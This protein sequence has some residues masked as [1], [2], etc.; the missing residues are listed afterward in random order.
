MLGLAV[1]GCIG[2]FHAAH[3]QTTF[4]ETA[5]G[6]SSNPQTITVT[7]Q[8]TGAVSAVSVLTL[9]QS[10]LDFNPTV[11]G[12]NS[13]TNASF[14]TAGTSSC[15]IEITFTP[16]YPGVRNG[17]IV[18]TGS[19]GNVLAT[20]YLTGTGQGSLGVMVPG[21]MQTAVGTGQWT[22]VNDGG[23]PLA[24]DLDLPSSVA[25][26]GAGNLYIADSAHNRIREVSA[27]DNVISTICGT[28]APGSTGD[29]QSAVNATLNTPRSVAIDGAGNLYIAD[30]GNNAIRE[31][32]KAT[33]DIATIAGNGVPANLDGNAA[34][35]ELNNP[36][37]VTVDAAGDVYIADTSD[38][39]ILTVAPSSNNAV[40]IA[41]DG[42]AGFAGDGGAAKLAELNLP[43]AVAF[44]SLE[45]IYIPDSGN[46]CV[47]VDYV[48]GAEAGKI[49]TFAGSCHTGT[50]S[51]SGDGG[52]PAN[53]NLFAPSAVAIDA[54][55][56]LYI[57][58]TQNN[59]IRKVT[60]VN[61]QLVIN[62][63][64]GTGIGI[65]G[66]DGGS[67][68]AAE[69]FGPYGVTLDG[70]G[71]LFIA[72]YFDHRIREVQSGT[73]TLTFDSLREDQVSPAQI[74][75]I[76]NDGNA[77]MT[78]T[79]ITPDSN[80][81]IGTTTNACSTTASVIIDGTCNVAAEFA[82]TEV[83]SPITGNI[84]LGVTGNPANGPLDIQVSGDALALNSTTT[85]LMAEPNPANFGAQVTLSA[86]VT[87]GTGTLGGSV[88][89]KDGTAI[90]GTVNLTV[91]SSPGTTG[92]ASFTTSALTVGTH[93]LTAVYNGD[94]GVHSASTSPAVSEDIQEQ[95]SVA[96]TSGENPSVSGDSVT[97]TATVSAT[98]D[99]GAAP[100][101]TVNFLSG[102]A[103][104]GTGTLSGNAASFT[105][106]GLTTGTH[107][108]TAAYVGDSDNAGSTSPQL[109]QVVK[110]ITSTS[111]QSSENPASFGDSVRFTATVS[112]GSAT[113][114]GIVTFTD[115]ANGNALLGSSSLINVGSSFTAS[116]SSS[117]L[118]VASH[119]IV[120][121]YSG[122]ANDV[123]S[124]S[125]G[126]AE[127]VQ[128]AST[129]TSLSSSLTPSAS[130]QSVSF[131]VTVHGG[132]TA[133]TGT[134]SLLDGTATVSTMN[135]GANGTV[136]IPVSALSVGTHSLTAV[137]SGD[138]NYL[139]ST[140]LVI[141]QKVLPNTTAILSSSANPSIAGTNVSITVTVSGASGTPTGNVN[142]SDGATPL[143]TLTLVGG[144]ANYQTTS[145][146]VGPHSLT[147]AYAG[148][149]NN[150]GTTSAAYVQ[151]V[152]QATT[153]TTVGASANPATAGRTISLIATV[154]GNG[155]TPGGQVRFFS[156]GTQVG[157]ATLSGGTASLPISSLAVGS[158]SIYATYVGDPN[159]A[160]S[161]SSTY[162]LSV[163]QA[164]SSVNLTSSQNPSVAVRAVGFTAT[165]TGSGVT[166]TGNV[167][168]SDGGISL[169][170]VA[171]TPA[172][173]ANYVTSGLA[174]GVH[175]ITAAYQG[176]G[177]NTASSTSLVQTVTQAAPTLG[178]TS[179]L[180]PSSAGA[181]VTFTATPT[182]AAGTPSGSV[183]FSD[184]S[185][186]IGTA[187]L[188]PQGAATF[189]TSSLSVGQH[190]IT[191]SYG[192]DANNTGAI[193][194]PLT[195][196]VQEMTTTSL[197]SS[198]NPSIGGT[199]VTLTATVL[200]ASSGAISGSV[201][202]KSGNS[203][204][205]AATLSAAGVA[206][207]TT[208]A[209][210]VGSDALTAVYSGDTLHI[211]STSAELTQ[212]VQSA[213]T[214]TTLASNQ[215][216]SLFGQNVTFTATVS[217]NGI[218][219]TGAITF[220]DGST[221]LATVNVNTAG[222]ASYS[223]TTLSIGVH[224]IVASYSGDSDDQKSTS[225]VV[226]QSVQSQTSVALASS[227]N[228]AL[229]A[230][231]VTFTAT[232]TNGNGT[233]PTG[234][235]TIN[236]GSSV[237]AELTL[238]A[239]GTV[240]FTTSTLPVGT[241]SITAA[242][243]GD[244]DDAA[245]KSGTLAQVIQAIPTKTTLGA[246]AA[247]VTTQQPLTLVASVF[248]A[249][250][251][252]L[253][254]TV[255][256]EN[257]TT[258]IG[259]AT[260]TSA[261]TATL[262]PTLTTGTYSI[263]AVYSGDANNAVSTSVPVSVTV[264]EPIDFQMSL[265]PPAVTVVTKQYTT[266]TLTITSTDG[267][268]DQLGLGCGSLPA[269]ITCNFSQQMV[270]LPANG[271]VTAQVTIDTASPLTSGGS[272]KNEMPGGPSSTQLAWIFP[273]G[274]LFGLIW[275]RARKK[276]SGIFCTLLL[277]LLSAAAFTVTGCGGLNESSAQPGTYKIEV[278]ANGVKTGMD[279]A[280]DVTVT[281]NQ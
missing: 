121:T 151:T 209:L 140:S 77:A 279:H 207:L 270:T 228:P 219:P 87:T 70:Q 69:I 260:L 103:M 214:T 50:G 8:A 127:T 22:E 129:T 155:A 143:A 169:A 231:P 11:S 171:L 5:V 278:T 206:S 210:A 159:D 275:W 268:T 123:A 211:A 58:D 229:A 118:S 259:S 160:G 23:S 164:T 55:G 178:L 54:A 44:D 173:V 174:P 152:N 272:A 251:A 246:S 193:S 137:Y 76:E 10:G 65:Y 262:T 133:P 234:T 128:K 29:G 203:V 141:S 46:N 6:A 117:A 63:V 240:S 153:S 102:G 149:P 227:L 2:A 147:A 132:T 277:I 45:N 114:T 52:A 21:T 150:A 131:T 100:T 41:G 18:L 15:Q 62:T 42:V 247:A 183:L 82:P 39:R 195:Q 92:T 199:P 25:V 281:V 258:A 261:G 111:V 122:D 91:P 80:A 101:G 243:G 254:G 216:P 148:D 36:L 202:Y 233:V 32:N 252:P 253:T 220:T 250:S 136:V 269:S 37:G 226:N 86:T 35:V 208:S 105:Y 67:A 191:A 238:P 71:D 175:T 56:N 177:N 138:G 172:G 197:A 145:L 190:T 241:H 27:A 9:G 31:I 134:V 263:V 198:K 274:A 26:D 192:G 264:T 112:N 130:G 276:Y 108:I 223:T 257:G 110:A 157:T 48:T 237:L 119:S 98:P 19:G 144:V 93:S 14:S 68:T 113:P 106:S 7:A 28:G 3:G 1:L 120:A 74:Q 158:D 73:V 225:A 235:V 84:D 165:V 47:R 271:S 124:A 57:G 40:T 213:G 236:D 168:F 17:A 170:T 184:G 232:V 33:G 135:V 181:S 142:L 221:P 222:V 212:T 49:E 88:N 215:N 248:S 196:T 194:A 218:V 20:Q 66:G 224:Q 201:T 163:V 34:T 185:A 182:G 217:G 13:C 59:R 266:V 200:G 245:A 230:V 280:V 60:T 125:T 244:T 43:Y 97:F 265:N 95:T 189:S 204:V 81:Q 83:G 139:T 156:Q 267:F 180:N 94:D 4:L 242:Y 96:V 16:K 24:A 166:P 161:T 146:V 239:N 273:G 154:T 126:L 51:F 186:P 188:S 30:S 176:D 116:L 167:I 115:A 99:G 90:L 256:F 12:T 85:A 64:A 89:F 61:S 162:A 187:S 205:G 75:A 104:I 78:L 72:D 249:G 79:A 109:S 179:N 53:A 38:Q 107:S 255:T